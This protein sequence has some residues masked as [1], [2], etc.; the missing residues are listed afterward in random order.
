MATLLDGRSLAASLRYELHT[1]IASLTITPR[2]G[3]LLIGDDPASHLYVNLKEK[4]AAEVGIAV[5]KVLLP[6]NTTTNTALEHLAAFNQ[7]PDVHAIL[8]QLPLPP[9][10]NEH[11]IISALN[12]S[13][14]AD[15]FHP[16]NL[17][18]LMAGQPAIVPG[19]SQG[20]MK[21]IELAGQ[22]LKGKMAA[23]VVNSQ[24][25]ALPLVKL[26]NDRSVQ[27]TVLRAPD[28]DTLRMADIV[29]V[30]LGRPGIITSEHLKDGAI[31]IDVGTTKVGSRV[32]GD[33]LVSSLAD[34]SVFL[35]PVPGG[36]GPMTVAMLLWNVYHLAKQSP[37]V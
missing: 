21:L 14:D 16:Q 19:V 36:V 25:F 23:L 29:V 31:V 8:V 28:P 2:L 7:R 11:Q 33:V 5:E 26:L 30:A 4:A 6:E 27:V 34:R 1:K 17:Q 18:R 9:Q 15:G 20:I 22:E 3:V 35:T 24:E 32:R 12:P 37:S 10:L 13:K